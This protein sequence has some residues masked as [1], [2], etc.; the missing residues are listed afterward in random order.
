MEQAEAARNAS[1]AFFGEIR[2]FGRRGNQLH[3]FVL[4]LGS[5]FGLAHRRPSQS[6]SEQS[7]FSIRNGTEQLSAEDYNFLA[8]AVK[9]S[10]L[11]EHIDTKKKD[12]YKPQAVE[13]I[14]NPIYAPYFHISYRKKRKLELSTSDVICLLRGN[15][16]EFTELMKRYSKGWGIEP[17]EVAPVPRSLFD[18]VDS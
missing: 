11:Y 3:T 16:K 10:V 13:Y 17:S 15:L 1:A 2:S 8:E 4:R 6:E 9:W 18:E 14:L 5:L 7:H 12:E